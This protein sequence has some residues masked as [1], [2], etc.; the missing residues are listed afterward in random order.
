MAI[1]LLG[2]VPGLFL[3]LTLM[4][5]ATT[6]RGRLFATGVLLAIPVPVLV[7]VACYLER[8]RGLLRAAW[9][10]AVASICLL[11]IDYRISP[12]NP[13][14]HGTG[15]R[16]I[17]NEATRFHRA[18]PANLVPEID[19]LILGTYVMPSLDRLMDK[20][21]TEELR[22]GV[23]DVYGEMRQSSDFERLGSAL[24]YTYGDLSLRQRPVGHMYEY[25]PERPASQ[26]LPVVIFLHGSLGNF[27]GYM[28]VWKK[29]ADA[30]GV[31]IVAPTFGAGNW[32]APGGV[33]ALEN[34]RRYCLSN[35]RFDPARIFLA[36]LS[37]GGRGTCMEVQSAP[38]CYRGLIFIS[39]V[40]YPQP[41]ESQSFRD[42]WK[43]K[44][45]LVLHGSKDNRIPAAYVSS[46]VAGMRSAGLPVTYRLYEG[47]THFLFFTLRT[48]VQDLIGEWL[49]ETATGTPAHDQT[50]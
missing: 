39:P 23:L 10:L 40:L 49:S 44:R 29:I 35:P 46:S 11:A 50:R 3:A 45:V 43:S 21:N 31:A 12:D 48:E 28:W 19:Q 7:W 38:D 8:K 1:Y 17:R 14:L 18:S 25:I 15:I 41:W 37:N 36:G 42:A 4:V 13:Q 47:Q 20:A 22:S 6:W 33:A 16:S 34:A 24:G 2:V 32:D 5:H 26:K 27:R 9:V 30:Q